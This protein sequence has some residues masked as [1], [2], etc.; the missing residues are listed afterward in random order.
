MKKIIFI[1]CGL[2]FVCLSTQA[3]NWIQTGQKTYLDRSSISKYNDIYSRNSIYSFWTKNLYNESEFDEFLENKYGHKYWY[4]KVLVLMDCSN[5]ERAVKSGTWYNL[6]EK[7][8][9]NGTS[10]Y[11]DY[12]LQWSPVIPESIGEVEYNYVCGSAIENDDSYPS[13]D[14]SPER[15]DEMRKAWL[16]GGER[17]STLLEQDPDFWDKYGHFYNCQGEYLE[18]FGKDFETLYNYCTAGSM[19]KYAKCIENFLDI[20]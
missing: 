15:I 5:K 17:C 9:Y 13:L 11:D 20:N 16:Y 3:A 14:I 1:L 12:S 7:V 18:K 2:G 10:V 6:Q 4:S 8:T 19:S